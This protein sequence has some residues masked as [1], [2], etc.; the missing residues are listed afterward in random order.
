MAARV[1]EYV[2]ERIP[3]FPRRSEDTGVKPRSEHPAAAAER[4]VERASDARADR[5]HP[6][7][8]RIGVVGL[9]EEVSVRGLKAVVDEAE[10]ATVPR[11][12][13]ASLERAHEL[14]GA[15]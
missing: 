11:L 13:E 15:Q 14:H 1:Q 6:T 8:E 10:V 2:G 9:D 3:H 7:C 12:P 4:P 5:H